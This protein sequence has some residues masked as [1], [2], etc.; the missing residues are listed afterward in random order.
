M[1]RHKI[2]L[3]THEFPPR[4]GGAGVYCEE[5]A[6]AATSLGHEVRV[7]APEKLDTDSNDSLPYSISSLPLRGSQDWR[8]SLG[9]IRE[10]RRKANEFGGSVLH[11]AEPGSL[12]TFVRFGS[13]AGFWPKRLII[14]LHGSEIPLFSR[15]PLEKLFFRKLLRKANQIHLLSYFNKK[16][17]LARF[18]ELASKIVLAPGAARRLL[19]P[20]KIPKKDNET[21]GKLR[22]LTVG[23]LHPRKGQD[24]ILEAIRQMPNE[25]KSALEYYVIGP[26]VRPHYARGLRQQADASGIPVHFL[27]DLQ[28]H[29]VRIAY[30]SSD[31]FALTSVPHS[32]SVEGFGFVYLEAAAH[33]LP[34]LA[35]RTG[36]VE[37]AVVHNETGLL[38]DPNDSSDLTRSLE[39]LIRD[40][41]LRNRLGQK[42]RERA[43][44]F[45]W[46]KTAKTLYGEA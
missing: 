19:L 38:A 17:L 27:G 40:D 6:Y 4:R 22:L 26:E 15:S 29:D 41:K 10:V 23:R 35:N 43:E 32:R 18:P 46:R 34:A 3:L 1:A 36:G 21:E 25:L 39:S 9:L 31:L 7:W 45:T 5:M 28:D 2:N 42:A 11:L 12:R 16:A 13:F 20:S 37:D 33:G 44:G 24:R 8:C 30:E 14:T